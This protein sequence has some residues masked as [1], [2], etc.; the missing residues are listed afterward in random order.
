MDVF[1]CDPEVESGCEEDGSSMMC[2]QAN[3]IPTG[4]KKDMI[5]SMS[6]NIC[7]YKLQIENTNEEFPF[8]LTVFRDEAVTLTTTAL[9]LLASGVYQF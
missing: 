8:I 6:A 9:V 3:D 2:V 4:Y 5:L 1:E 7:A